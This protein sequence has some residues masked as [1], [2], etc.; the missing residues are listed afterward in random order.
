MELYIEKID[1]ELKRIGKSRHWLA[2]ELDRSPQ[3]VYYWLNTKSLRGAE[4]I[5]KALK[6]HPKD[7]IRG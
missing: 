5:A 1:A 7:L 2:I 6:L 4:P 3:L